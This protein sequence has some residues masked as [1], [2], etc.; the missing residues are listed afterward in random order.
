MSGRVTRIAVT[1]IESGD[2][3]TMHFENDRFPPLWF[4][5]KTRP[6]AHAKLRAILAEI[7]ADE[8]GEYARLAS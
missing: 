3:I 4:N 2:D 8:A 7:E 5:R 6:V 1:L